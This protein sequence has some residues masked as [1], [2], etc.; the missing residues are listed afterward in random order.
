M[1]AFYTTK[2]VAKILNYHPEYVRELV[3][4]GKLES[5]NKSGH[6]RFTDKEIEDFLKRGK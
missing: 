1:K 6:Y 5:V 3:R 4:K 2:D